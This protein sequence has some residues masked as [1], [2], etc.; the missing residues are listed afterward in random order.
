MK[1][2]DQK[3]VGLGLGILVLIFLSLVICFSS[4][5]FSLASLS[6]GISFY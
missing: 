1:A 6:L 3:K 5:L 4:H 2:K